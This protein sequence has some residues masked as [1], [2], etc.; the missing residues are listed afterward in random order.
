MGP[1]RCTVKST[2]V[3]GRK[4]ILSQEKR[5]GVWLKVKKEECDQMAWLFFLHLHS[6]NSGNYIANV[7]SKF[8]QIPAE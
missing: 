4:E 3:E 6:Y 2:N 8:P 7:G 5:G 1:G